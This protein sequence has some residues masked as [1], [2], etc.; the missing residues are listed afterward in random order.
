[1]KKGADVKEA[2]GVGEA[3][4][5]VDGGD[6]SVFLKNCQTEALDVSNTYLKAIR[7]AEGVFS[8]ASDEL[9]WNL[10]ARLGGLHVDCSKCPGRC[11]KEVGYG[12]SVS[13]IVEQ[14]LLRFRQYLDSDER[15]ELLI[16]FNFEPSPGERGSRASV[17]ISELDLVVIK[18]AGGSPDAAVP[19]DVTRK[20]VGE[21]FHG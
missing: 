13:G 8:S 7:A 18:D 19:T 11:L 17:P 20:R 10:T 16:C 3:G 6:L 9:E 2:D 5:K 12:T 1:M 14:V 4:G 15:Q 21:V